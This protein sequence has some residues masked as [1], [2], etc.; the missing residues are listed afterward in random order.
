[1]NA[2][3]DPTIPDDLGELLRGASRAQAVTPAPLGSVQHRARQRR[4][5]RHGVVACGA[6]AVVLLAGLAIAQV[7]T[8][9]GT[10]RVETATTVPVDGRGSAAQPLLVP[11][12][13]TAA[14][15]V[16]DGGSALMA[17]RQLDE[18]T[19]AGVQRWWTTEPG[20]RPSEAVVLADGRRFGIARAAGEGPLVSNE[21]SEVAL[22]EIGP[23][24]R[25]IDRRVLAV[26]APTDSTTSVTLLGASGTEVVL[27]RT[28]SSNPGTG[29]PGDGMT[30]VQITSSSTVTA[31]DVD[32]GEERPVTEGTGG[33]LAAAAG[34]VLVRSV[35]T[36]CTITVQPLASD[37]DP[38]ELDG[39]CP[40][41]SEDLD[42]LEGMA[43]GLAVSP[44]GRYAGVLWTMIRMTGLPDVRVAIIDL[45]T[46]EI[47]QDGT[48]EDDE[49]VATMAWTGDRTLSLAVDEDGAPFTV[50]EGPV[51]VAAVPW[52]GM[53]SD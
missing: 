28:T 4:R 44:D 18:L 41:T 34:D 25:T 13:P 14:E 11:G 2:T 19:S 23:G 31:L 52:S 30:G 53:S 12:G 36:D 32:T 27:E 37:D 51:E 1:M 17:G 20:W 48:Q 46:G 10:E 26:D 29:G 40:T 38:R 16:G 47:V 7:A 24:G 35:G 43:I 21:E 45:G 22:D 50:G 39:G 33:G 9:D 15:V 3:D 42:G 8:D 6:A 5:R 49:P